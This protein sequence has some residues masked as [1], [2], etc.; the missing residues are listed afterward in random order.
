MS[1]L[2]CN[3]A[4]HRSRLI[5][6]LQCMVEEVPHMKHETISIEV[7]ESD[8]FPFIFHSRVGGAWE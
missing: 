6:D 4:D 1:Q 2:R 8:L 5:D 7:K 3:P